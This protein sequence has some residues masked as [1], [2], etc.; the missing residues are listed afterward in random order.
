MACD[1]ELINLFYNIEESLYYNDS[2]DDTDYNE[3]LKSLLSKDFSN[4]KYF[5]NWFYKNRVYK[6]ININSIITPYSKKLYQNVLYGLMLRENSRYDLNSKSFELNIIFRDDNIDTIDTKELSNL[7]K[8]NCFNCKRVILKDGVDLL[9]NLKETL[10]RNDY[11]I[12]YEVVSL[13]ELSGDKDVVHLIVTDVNIPFLEEFIVEAK[14]CNV[15]KLYITSSCKSSNNRS[16]YRSNIDKLVYKHMTLDFH[17]INIDFIYGQHLYID[18]YMIGL[19]NN[20]SIKPS[21]RTNHLYTDVKSLKLLHINH[22]Y[23]LESCEQCPEKVLCML[24]VSDIPCNCK[25]L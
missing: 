8:L 6:T 12:V 17:I 21:N 4:M 20:F 16:Y 15:K 23:L 11:E 5:N 9:R 10:I 22:T 13:S 2:N 7:H 19:K 24:G 18:D 1:K 3:E 25:I 14:R